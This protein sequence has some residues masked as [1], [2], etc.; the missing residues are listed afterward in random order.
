MQSPQAPATGAQ[1]FIPS[2]Q[3]TL[4]VL[5]E[6]ARACRGCELYQHAT[7][8]VFGRGPTI[9]TVMLVGE[10]PGD[11]EDRAGKPFVGPAGRVLDEALTAAGIDRAATYVTN[12]VKHFKF[13][14]ADRGP[15]RIHKTPGATEIVACRPWLLAEMAVVK[16]RVLVLLGATAGK[17]LLGSGFSVTRS[18]GVPLDWPPNAPADVTAIRLLATI[19]PSAVLRADDPDAMMAGLISDLT[20]VRDL[21]STGNVG[22]DANSRPSRSSRSASTNQD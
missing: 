22:K 2:G 17:A 12:A 14:P 10:Q 5:A 15:R 11:Q 7:Q 13:V 6:A 3:L 8:T 9:A 16:P 19:H 20:Q 18:R 1:A 4:P 21:L